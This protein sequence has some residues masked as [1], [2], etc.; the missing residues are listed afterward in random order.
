MV[1]AKLQMEV[2]WWSRPYIHG[3]ANGKPDECGFKC[4]RCEC[5]GDPGC[6]EQ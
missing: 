3:D 4:E 2:P 1:A 5:G 6:L